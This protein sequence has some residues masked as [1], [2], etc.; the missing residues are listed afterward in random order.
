MHFIWTIAFKFSR[1]EYRIQTNRF[2]N[3][4]G[5]VFFSSG[6]MDLDTESALL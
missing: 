5:C 2:A 4:D 1:L 6:C 3:N